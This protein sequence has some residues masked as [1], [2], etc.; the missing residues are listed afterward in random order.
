MCCFISL[1]LTI[2]PRVNDLT[3]STT[4]GMVGSRRPAACINKIKAYYVLIELNENTSLEN[5]RV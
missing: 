5:K 2:P 4:S 3:L 1:T